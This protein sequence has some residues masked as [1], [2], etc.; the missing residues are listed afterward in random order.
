MKKKSSTKKVFYIGA[1]ILV[2]AVGLGFMVN[3][4]EYNTIRDKAK[5]LIT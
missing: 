3:Y 1:L 4:F 5:K 2:V